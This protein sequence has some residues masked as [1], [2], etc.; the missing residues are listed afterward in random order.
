M[1]P[2]K[3]IILIEII[4]GVCSAAIAIYSIFAT[5][6]GSLVAVPIGAIAA[7]IAAMLFEDAQRLHR[8]VKFRNKQIIHSR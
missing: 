3:N 8:Y 5:V 6:Q 4:A 1:K 2:I 7:L